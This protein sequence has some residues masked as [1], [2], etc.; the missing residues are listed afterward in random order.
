MIEEQKLEELIKIYR[1]KGKQCEESCVVGIL[2]SMFVMTLHPNLGFIPCFVMTCVGASFSFAMA[3][4]AGKHNKISEELSELATT[5]FI[6]VIPAQVS[7][8][9]MAVIFKSRK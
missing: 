7:D 4:W 1:N 2:F 9:T 3:L 5:K 6:G 8:E